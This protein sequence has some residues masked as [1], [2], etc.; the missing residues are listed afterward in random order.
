MGDGGDP[1]K[2]SEYDRKERERNKFPTISA[3]RRIQF[4][5]NR[6]YIY[7]IANILHGFMSIIRPI[8]FKI[9]LF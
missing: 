3:G 5:D 4:A 9:I 1:E 7:I 8:M 2:N 6:A